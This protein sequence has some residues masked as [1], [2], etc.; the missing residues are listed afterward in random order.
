VDKYLITFN[1]SNRITGPIMVTTSPRSTCPASCPLRGSVCYAENGH[2]GNLIWTGLDDTPA[3]KT[4]GNGIRVYNFAQ[5]LIAIRCLVPGSVWRHNQAGDLATTDGV[6]IDRA[7]IRALTEANKGRKCFTFTHHAPT[8]ENQETIKE[9]CDNG[10]TINL[11]ADTLE[12][13]D[14][15]ADLGIAPV[16][17]VINPTQK[18]NLTTPKGRRVTICPAR[19]KNGIT[20]S[21]CQICTK[22]HKAIIA[23]P[24]L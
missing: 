18:E 14:A 8:P 24:R 2:L 23:F 17:V 7:K 22:P 6:T 5:L 13:A 3:H 20:C 4:F 1:S 19:R 9:A 12:E 16:C 10:F 11:S 21:T 15:L